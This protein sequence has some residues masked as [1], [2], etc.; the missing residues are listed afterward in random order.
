[1]N[2]EVVQLMEL[3]NGVVQVT[4]KDEEYRNTLSQGIMEGLSKCFDAISRNNNYKVVILT[5]Y[6]NYFASG[7]TKEHLLDIYKGDAKCNDSDIFKIALDCEIPVIAAMQGHAIG[8]GLVSGLYAD[9]VVL[10]KESIYTT[11]FMKYGFTPGIGATFIVP[12]KLGYALGQEMMYTAQNYRGAELAKRGIQFPVLPRKEVLS[13]ARNMAEIIA[14]KPRL[15]LITLKKHLT[16]EI[17]N[18]LPKWIDKE[19]AMHEITFHQPSVASQI[20]LSFSN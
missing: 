1:M 8:G 14:E 3:D 7:G 10:S 4:I 15:S 2:T 18:K 13:Y 12:F 6:G 16:S 9:L 11:N 20:E 17:R 5:G 19:V